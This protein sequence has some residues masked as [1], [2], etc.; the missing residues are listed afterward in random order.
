MAFHAGT[1]EG[2]AAVAGN[3]IVWRNAKR[4]RTAAGIINRIPSIRRAPFTMTS[5][6]AAIVASNTKQMNSAFHHGCEVP[7]GI[8]VTQIKNSSDPNRARSSKTPTLKRTGNSSTATKSTT[9]VCDIY[10][11][12]FPALTVMAIG[13]TTCA[14]S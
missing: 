11:A 5:T 3:E 9:A 13:S 7:Y 2:M 12:T 1:D 6:T 10:P 14:A 8:A 4:M